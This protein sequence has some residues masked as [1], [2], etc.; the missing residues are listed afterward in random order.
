MDKFSVILFLCA[1]C[2]SICVSGQ[3]SGT[4]PKEEPK[5]PDD[6][7]FSIGLGVLSP[8]YSQKFGEDGKNNVNFAL[9]KIFLF[10]FFF[11]INKINKL[12]NL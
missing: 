6:Q 3:Q 4:L 12:L 10:F 5:K 9:H 7:K 8:S 2:A 11:F 1:Y